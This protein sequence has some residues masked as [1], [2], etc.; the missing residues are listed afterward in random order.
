[1]MRQE[2]HITLDKDPRCVK[3]RL[4]RVRYENN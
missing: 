1:M 4:I 2:Q 3:C